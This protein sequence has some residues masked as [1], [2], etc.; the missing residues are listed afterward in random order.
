MQFDFDTSA[1]LLLLETVELRVRELLD[2]ATQFSEE[3]EGEWKDT[4]K[5]NCKIL[6]WSISHSVFTLGV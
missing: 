4:P 6:W 1:A 5:V 3:V 2:N